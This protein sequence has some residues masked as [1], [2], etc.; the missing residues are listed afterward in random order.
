M[1]GHN[2][3]GFQCFLLKKYYPFCENVVQAKILPKFSVK[4][5]NSLVGFLQY[6]NRFEQ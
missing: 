5:N 3:T 4:T 6:Y 1:H 2:E